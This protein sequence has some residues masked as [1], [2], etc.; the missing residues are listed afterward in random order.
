MV[1]VQFDYSAGSCKKKCLQL[2]PLHMNRNRCQISRLCS[3]RGRT[4][5]WH[6][7]PP[8]KRRMVS[9]RP[10]RRMPSVPASQPHTLQTYIRTNTDRR[11]DT[12]ISGSSASSTGQLSSSMLFARCPAWFVPCSLLPHFFQRKPFSEYKATD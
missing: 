10:V 1:T 4:L 11:Q 9:L 2:L 12:W 8:P 3:T 6:E 5:N 7:Q